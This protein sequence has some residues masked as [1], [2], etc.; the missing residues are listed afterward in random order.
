MAAAAEQQIEQREPQRRRGRPWPKGVS[1]NPA[2][3]RVQDS[4]RQALQ[5]E[6]TAELGG[7]VSP[8][9][10]LLLQRAVELLTRRAKSH[11]DSVRGINLA[12]RIIGELRRRYA[13]PEVVPSLDEL[14]L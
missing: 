3:S 12:H 11:V 9:D 2:G 14:G 8:A 1:G 5:I 4:R 7:Q 10:K 6:I 13:Q